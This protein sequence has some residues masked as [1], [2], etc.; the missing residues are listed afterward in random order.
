MFAA[1][2]TS[3]QYFSLTLNQHQPPAT[4][5]PTVIFSH[6][7]SVPAISRSRQNRVNCDTLFVDDLTSTGPVFLKRFLS[8]GGRDVHVERELLI[9]HYPGSYISN[10]MFSIL[11]NILEI[12]T[13]HHE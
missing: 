9:V 7:K 5:Q 8:D 12:F 13:P 2:P 6:N 11:L 4:S 3:Q 10:L 1:S